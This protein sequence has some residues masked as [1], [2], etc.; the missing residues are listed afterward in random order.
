M[1]EPL[2]W[3]LIGT[4]GIAETFAA[5]LMFTESSR[6]AAVGSRQMVGGPIRRSVQH[7]Q[8]AREL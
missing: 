4:G 5:D 2:G 6:V 3:G 7:S 1:T 8:P